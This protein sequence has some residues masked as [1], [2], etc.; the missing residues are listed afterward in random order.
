VRLYGLDAQLEW[1]KQTLPTKGG[2]KYR[3]IGGNHD[4]SFIKQANAD[5]LTVLAK[6]RPDFVHL[7]N[8][9][10]T[11]PLHGLVVEMH[12]GAGGGAYSLSYPLQ[13]FVDAIPGGSKPKI[14]IQGHHHNAFE[15]FYRNI[16]AYRPGCFQGE[17]LFT[18]RHGLHPAPGG[19]LIEVWTDSEGGIRK[20]RNEFF[21][22]YFR[23]KAVAHAMA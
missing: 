17:T 22:F 10:A 1:A 16:F 3:A 6:A 23:Q 9:D 7:G 2:L 4:V 8:Y 11:F 14:L 18:K 21:P 12:H 15:M 5:I 20:I 13:R 19:Y